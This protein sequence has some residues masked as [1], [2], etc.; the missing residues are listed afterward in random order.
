MTCYAAGFLVAVAALLALP[1]Q[2]QAQTVQTLRQQHRANNSRLSRNCLGNFVR[3]QAQ[4]FT[5]GTD[6][7]GYTLGQVVLS[8]GCEFRPEPPD[9]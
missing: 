3:T 8:F 5:T 1:L 4:A 6:A 2:A 9:V 7:G